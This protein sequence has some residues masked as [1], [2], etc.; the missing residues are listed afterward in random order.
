VEAAK[1]D[2]ALEL[3]GDPDRLDLTD[4]HCRMARDRGAG[5]VLGSEA[6]TPEEFERIDF[7]L[8]QARRGWLEPRHLLNTAPISRALKRLRKKP[9]VETAA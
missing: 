1:F 2:V 6:R 5:I 7:A 9:E 3:S 4:V 8:M